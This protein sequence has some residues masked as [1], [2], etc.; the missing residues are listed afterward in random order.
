MQRIFLTQLVLQ[1]SCEDNF[2]DYTPSHAALH[3]AL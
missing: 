2:S 1:V 3:L